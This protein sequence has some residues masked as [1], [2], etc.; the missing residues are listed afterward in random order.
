LGSTTR[1]ASWRQIAFCNPVSPTH[2][3]KSGCPELGGSEGEGESLGS[4]DGLSLG[5]SEGLSLGESDGPPLG[6][7]E[8]EGE[9]TGDAGL[10]AAVTR[11]GAAAATVPAAT[12]MASVTRSDLSTFISRYIGR[13]ADT[14]RTPLAS[15][16]GRRPQGKGHNVPTRGVCGVG[17]VDVGDGDAGTGDGDG[18]TGDGGRGT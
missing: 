17:D 14:L 18:G 2:A 9:T 8:S 5:E 13:L 6:L 1:R 12:V 4:V 11:C 3:E 10:V 15:D 16:P 7:G